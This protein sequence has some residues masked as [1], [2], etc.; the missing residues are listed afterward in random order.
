MKKMRRR[1]TMS[2]I[3]AICM[4]AGSGSRLEN[5]MVLRG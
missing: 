3:G 2:I 1:K 4:A 5:F